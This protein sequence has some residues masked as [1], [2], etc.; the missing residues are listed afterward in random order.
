M[1]SE[2]LESEAYTHLSIPC[3][4]GCLFL[5]VP[6]GDLGAS[7]PGSSPPHKDI[8]KLCGCGQITDP[9]CA[10]IPETKT[11]IVLSPDQ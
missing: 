9:L 8:Y 2:G 5:M 4:C 1:R 7:P 6:L 11:V 3:G 10:P